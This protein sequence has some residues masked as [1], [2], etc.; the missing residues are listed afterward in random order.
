MTGRCKRHG[1][2]AMPAP[3]PAYNGRPMTR[4]EPMQLQSEQ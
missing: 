4:G 1:I 3:A 2:A